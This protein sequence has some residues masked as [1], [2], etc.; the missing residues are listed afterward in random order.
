[1]NR[2]TFIKLST[3]STLALAASGLAWR[4]GGV[5]WDQAKS[6]R[7]KVM[8]T[9]EAEIV[10]AIADAMFPGDGE[11]P[12]GTEVGAID[13]FDRYLASIDPR[14]S[15][16]LRVLLHAIDDMGAVADFGMTRFRLRPRDERIAILQAWDESAFFGR[17]SAFRGVKLVVSTAYCEHPDVLRA[18]GIEFQCGGVA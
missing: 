9:T 3:A 1:M 13:F 10:N 6:P 15:K 2:R 17:R 12:N 18:A 16:L 4:V 5:W 11:F 14:T 7:L 8:S